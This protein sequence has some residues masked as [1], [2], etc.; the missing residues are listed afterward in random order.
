MCAGTF[1][2]RVRWIRLWAEYCC[3]G[4]PHGCKPPVFVSLDA[5][6]TAVVRDLSGICRHG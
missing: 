2:K 1:T 6:V 4:D 5:A 3:P